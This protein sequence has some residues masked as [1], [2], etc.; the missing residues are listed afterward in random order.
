[1]WLQC[2]SQKRFLKNS[3]QETL[4][5]NQIV[6]RLKRTSLCVWVK[7][8]VLALEAEFDPVV[9]VTE[10]HPKGSLS[11]RI[12]QREMVEKAQAEELSLGLLPGLLRWQLTE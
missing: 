11:D 3:G 6:S 10:N 8:G 5:V 1:M 2:L 9:K 12:E 7:N 4:D